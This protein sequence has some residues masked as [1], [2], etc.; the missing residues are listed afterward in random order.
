MIECLDDACARNDLAERL[1]GML[2]AEIDRLDAMG[3]ERIVRVPRVGRVRVE[4]RDGISAVDHDTP[5]PG[6]Q[7]AQRLSE[8]DPT[9]SHQHDI[10]AGGLLNGATLD[11]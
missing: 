3:S 9:Y 2:A 11:R 4:E 5:V 1:A 10:G 8:I 7:T 6:G